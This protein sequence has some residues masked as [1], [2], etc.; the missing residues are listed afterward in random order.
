MLIIVLAG[1]LQLTAGADLE[2][3]LGLVWSDRDGACLAINDKR[4][5]PWTQVFIV[6]V[7]DR[8]GRSFSAIVEAPVAA[9]EGLPIRF[10]AAYRLQLPLAATAP[11]PLPTCTRPAPVMP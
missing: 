5:R 11:G 4:L 2:E 8:P 3:R 6:A 10:H 1:L 7:D 9:C